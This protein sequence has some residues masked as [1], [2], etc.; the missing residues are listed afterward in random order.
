M[1]G[2]ILAAGLGTRLHPL[3]YEMPK[4]VVPVLGRPLCAW[5]MAFLARSGVKS[6]VLNLHQHPRLIQQAVLGWAGKRTPVQFTIEPDILGTGGGIGNARNHLKGGTFVTANGDTIVNF[7]FAQA[8]A[9]HRRK[10][11][12]ATLVLFPNRDKR[13]TP[14]WIRPHGRLAGFGTDAGDG[15]L[16]GFYTGVQIIEPELLD[17]IPQ[18][19]PSCIIRDIY[20]PL[21]ARGA[22]IHGFLTKGSFREFGTPSDYL[23]ETLALLGEPAERDPAPVFSAPG[24]E[25]IQ[26]AWISPRARIASGATIGPN[27]VIE[28]DAS[29]ETGARVSD[30]VV[31]PGAVL[32]RG[33]AVRGAVLTAQ[34]RLSINLGSPP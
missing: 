22:P 3:S 1:K 6:F 27:A 17:L 24:V 9:Y 4:P 19:K 11:S 2:M 10:K 5:T 25:V 31:W 12:L 7:N 26:P 18:G 23:R 21:I 15:R 32:G 28:A 34:R 13:Y 33:E 29:I 8:L 30:A 20:I 14:V 16:S